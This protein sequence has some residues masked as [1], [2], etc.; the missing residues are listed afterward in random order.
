[1]NSLPSC[2]LSK[3]TLV[4]GSLSP[5]SIHRKFVMAYS[6]DRSGLFYDSRDERERMRPPEPRSHVS[7]ADQ[8][9]T[10]KERDAKSYFARS[11]R[12]RDDYIFVDGSRFSTAQTVIDRDSEYVRPGS[13]RPSYVDESNPFVLPPRQRGPIPRFDPFDSLDIFQAWTLACEYD[14]RPQIASP[15]NPLPKPTDSTPKT[16]VAVTDRKSV[17]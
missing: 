14:L 11:A 10:T 13:K 17:V 16:K 4:K 1:M 15:F 2:L 3:Q 5:D 12:D 9:E 6:S 7:Y 8:P